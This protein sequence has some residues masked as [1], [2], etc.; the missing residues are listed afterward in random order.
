MILAD[1]E[2]ADV[3]FNFRNFCQKRGNGLEDLGSLGG[4]RLNDHLNER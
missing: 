2:L 1:V 3:A 4:W